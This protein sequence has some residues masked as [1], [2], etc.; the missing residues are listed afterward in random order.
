MRLKPKV[1]DT[2]KPYVHLAVGKS[3]KGVNLIT[4]IGMPKRAY[5]VKFR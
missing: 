1:Y 3:D 2:K 5:H 4:A